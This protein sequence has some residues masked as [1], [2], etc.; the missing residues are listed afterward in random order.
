MKPAEQ[1]R[2]KIEMFS[3]E[4]QAAISATSEVTEEKLM[5]RAYI[6]IQQR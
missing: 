1:R 3:N 2:S 5:E 4:K 6:K